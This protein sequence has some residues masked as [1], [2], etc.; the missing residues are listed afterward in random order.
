MNQLERDL[1]AS[2]TAPRRKFDMSKWHTKETKAVTATC[3]TACCLAGHIEAI[4]PKVTK[5]LLRRFL[6]E[7]GE[8]INHAGL[9]AAIYAQETGKP[10]RLDFCGSTVPKR[11]SEI[12]R[13]EAVAHIKGKNPDW[14]LLDF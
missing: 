6:Y 14:P 7:D 9:A 13:E 2:I 11:M 10:C 3:G 12:S 8:Y 5:Q 1:I 4:R